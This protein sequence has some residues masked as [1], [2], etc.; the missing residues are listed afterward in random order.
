MEQLLQNG[1][2]LRLAD[3]AAQLTE[4]SEGAIHFTSA[5]TT[6]ELAASA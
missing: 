4:L 5:S 3:M 1:L 2:T 6:L